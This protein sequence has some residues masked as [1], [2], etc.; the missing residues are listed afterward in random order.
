MQR[1]IGQAQKHPTISGV[2][3]ASLRW[4][5]SGNTVS[6]SRLRGPDVSLNLGPDLSHHV[7]FD[8]PPMYVDLL[9][10]PN[11]LPYIYPANRT[12]GAD[13]SICHHDQRQAAVDATLLCYRV[14]LNR[15]RDD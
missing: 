5:C 9:Y 15:F 10:H 8:L 3:F 13:F 7:S 1:Y 6:S 14:N 12:A 2:E 4:T 11:C